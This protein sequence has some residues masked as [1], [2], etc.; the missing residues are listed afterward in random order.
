[1]R[2]G[3]QL[4]TLKLLARRQQLIWDDVEVE[5]LDYSNL[6]DVKELNAFR[7]I[8]LQE[9]GKVEASYLRMKEFIFGLKNN[10]DIDLS[11]IAFLLSELLEYCHMNFEGFRKA[12]KK[13]NKNSDL[14]CALNCQ[15]AFFRRDTEIEAEILLIHQKLQTS[16]P[17]LI[18]FDKDGTLVDFNQS[19]GTWCVNFAKLLAK[20]ANLQ[21]IDDDIYEMM[22][23]DFENFKLFGEGSL[24]AWATYP[25]MRLY[26]RD[27]LIRKHNF[28]LQ[29]INDIL[30]RVFAVCDEGKGLCQG[31]GDIFALFE[32]I[33][34]NG[35]KVAVVTS[36]NRKSA[37]IELEEMKVMDFV[38]TLVC[39]D[40]EGIT[41]GKPAPYPLWKACE[42]LNI[43]PSRTWMVGDTR[44][45]L[46]S[47]R[48]AGCA[49]VFGVTSGVG[50]AEELRSSFKQI[51][52]NDYIIPSVMYF[53][54]MFES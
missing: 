26:T 11:H 44:A 15:N 40:D 43:A 20:E 4:E 29:E 19:W 45:D 21:D 3:V 27:Y 23:F 50:T 49:K 5:Y 35:I 39:G 30:D 8:F 38:S 52:S 16:R 54:E 37:E 31:L 18:I 48:S 14:K 36:D 32:T 25:E 53:Q 1:M 13:F 42:T 12:T 33:T 22:G 34:N 46:R 41:R 6:Y 2:F 9:L 17:E 24:L 7:E 47:G 51:C 10:E 28:A